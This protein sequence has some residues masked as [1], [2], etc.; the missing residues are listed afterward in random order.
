FA[1]YSFSQSVNLQE[2]IAALTLAE[3]VGADQL[4][5]LLPSYP[6]EPLPFAE[7]D[8]LKGLN[9]GSQLAGLAPLAAVS[10]QL[11]ALNLLGSAGSSNWA[12]APQRSRSGKS[13]LASDTRGA[14]ALSPVQIRTSK[15]QAA[16]FSLPGLP[17]VLSG[18]N[19]KLAWSSSAA[20]G[21]NQDLYLEKLRREGSRLMYLVDG[22]WQ[23]VQARN[24]TFFVK[25]QRPQRETL[26][27]TRH[28]TLLN[29]T[30][31]SLGLA[32]KMPELKGD[33]S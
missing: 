8:K 20:M 33:K 31:G 27:E 24:E 17:F 6:D 11:A 28:G 21:D 30:Q 25:G 19:G 14:W 4:A 7:A 15:Y 16:G 2:E 22:R 13:L 12:I 23:P 29:G 32:L 1:L 18:F 9:L 5:W 3:K 10:E 26:Y